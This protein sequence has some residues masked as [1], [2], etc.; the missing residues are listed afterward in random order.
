MEGNA[1]IWF[2]PQQKA[3]ARISLACAVGPAAAIT[4]YLST[5]TQTASGTAPLLDLGSR[6][7]DG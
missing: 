3:G 2:T 6:Q 1:R 7:G 5:Y 4:P